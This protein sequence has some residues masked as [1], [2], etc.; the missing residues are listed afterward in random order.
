MGERSVRIRVHVQPN[1]S[2]SEVAGWKEGIL[3]V[4]VTVSP[5][6]GKANQAVVKLLAERLDISKS[7]IRIK[8]G[9]TGRTKLIS[10]ASGLTEAEVIEKLTGKKQG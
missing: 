3:Q 7:S 2:R 9:L 10:I 5:A 4:K 8:K 1:A 6:E